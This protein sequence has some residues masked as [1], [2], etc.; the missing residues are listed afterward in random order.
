MDDV[1]KVRGIVIACRTP[2]DDEENRRL[3][4]EGRTDI[5]LY[6]HDDLLKSVV[7]LVK[8]VANV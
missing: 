5:E 2:T 3:R 8:Q 1:A 4:S 7:G 6:T